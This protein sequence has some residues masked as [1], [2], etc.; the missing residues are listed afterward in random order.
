M[1]TK[2]S[3]RS[4]L[5]S[6]LSTHGE[7]RVSDS[8]E[9]AALEAISRVADP[10]LIIDISGKI[11]YANE[12]GVRTFGNVIGHNLKD[13]IDPQAMNEIVVGG[14]WQEWKGDV[15]V[16][17]PDRSRFDGFLSTTPVLENG[18]V[19]SIVAIIQDITK[20]KAARESLQ[21]TEKMVTLGELVAGTSHELN[22]PLAI[23]TGYADLLLEEN[24]LTQ[25][26]RSKIESIRKNALRASGVVHSLLAFARKRKPERVR[27]DVNVAVEAAVD[28]KDYDLQ[29][30]G[31][32][33]EKHL[34]PA[35]PQVFADPNQVQQVLL[36][37]INNAQDA[38]SGVT[39]PTIVV[40]TEVRGELVLITVEDNGTG[41]TKSDLKKVFDPF[42]TTKSVGKGT[43]L[44]LSISY[45]IIREHNG[46]ITIQSESGQ[47]TQVFIELPIVNSKTE[48]A[49]RILVVDD[50]TDVLSILRTGLSWQGVTVDS[51]CTVSDAISLAGTI[52]YDF[53]LTDLKM[54]GSGIDLYHQLC[55][56]NPA[57]RRR[58]VFLTGDSSNPAS[59]QF[60]ENE[61]L[62]HFSKP[63]DFDAMR[64]YLKDRSAYQKPDRIV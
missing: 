49:M 55:G 50:E 48:G 32:H 31:I 64:R 35:L 59:V 7:A 61:G 23:V 44:G 26:Q 39:H 28:L 3:V 29:T 19:I 22:N 43:G 15:A 63:F 10:I 4:I 42:F 6:L 27:T 46:D 60:L 30:S 16:K 20:E 18:I 53:V 54:S 1:P 25:E 13:F 41:I 51:A 57:Y 17:R 58:T 40:R 33:L 36:N 34:S 5:T 2:F 24:T 12:S 9:R 52:T 47:G 62:T 45:G 56:I 8:L 38:V 37:V 11:T 14:A 21:Q